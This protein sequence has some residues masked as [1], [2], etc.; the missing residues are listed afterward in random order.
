M[1]RPQAP[2]IEGPGDSLAVRDRRA[3][4]SPTHLTALVGGSRRPCLVA[5]PGGQPV[6]PEPRPYVPVTLVTTTD[7]RV[8]RTLHLQRFSGRDGEV[9]VEMLLRADNAVTGENTKR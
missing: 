5:R 6:S 1:P 3:V 4:T 8:D 9:F 7:Q 2:W